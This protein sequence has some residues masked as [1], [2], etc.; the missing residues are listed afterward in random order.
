MKGQEKKRGGSPLSLRV[1]AVLFATIIVALGI[2]DACWPRRTFS[3]LENRNLAT[4][5]VLLLRNCGKTNTLW[6]TR[7]MWG[8]SLCC[9]TSGSV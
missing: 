3:E 7:S 4:D 1:M 2:L 5:P 8:T 9:G 6:N